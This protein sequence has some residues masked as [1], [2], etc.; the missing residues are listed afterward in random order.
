MNGDSDEKPDFP[1]VTFLKVTALLQVPYLDA[2]SCSLVTTNHMPGAVPSAV[3]RF[4]EEWRESSSRPR[5][6]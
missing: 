5:E 4:T 1:S 3:G 6:P 2:F